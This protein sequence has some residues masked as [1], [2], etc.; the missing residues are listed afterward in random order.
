MNILRIMSEMTTECAQVQCFEC[1]HPT[2]IPRVGFSRLDIA[3][4]P[5]C[6]NAQVRSTGNEGSGRCAVAA[7]QVSHRRNADRSLARARL[8]RMADDEPFLRPMLPL[9]DG[10][11]H[12]CANCC[13]HELEKIWASLDVMHL[14]ARSCDDD[15]APTGPAGPHQ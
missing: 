5:D 7:P 12:L 6:D 11:P 1:A 13:L 4:S 10:S 14:L 2:H 8:S 3:C 15:Q 9:P